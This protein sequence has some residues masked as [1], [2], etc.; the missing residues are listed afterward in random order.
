MKL[1][2][3][4]FNYYNGLILEDILTELGGVADIADFIMCD[5]LAVGEHESLAVLE[6]ATQIIDFRYRIPEEYITNE[7][8]DIWSDT[9]I[10]EKMH[11]MV[12]LEYLDY[13]KDFID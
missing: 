5:S 6:Y 3:T 10:L 12:I 13:I 9:E 4:D 7:N 1:D 2:L 11:K 8:L